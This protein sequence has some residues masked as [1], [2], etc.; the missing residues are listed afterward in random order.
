MIADVNKYDL[1]QW[2]GNKVCAAGTKATSFLVEQ[3]A[4]NST[5]AWNTGALLLVG[6]VAVITVLWISR[7]RQE[8]RDGYYWR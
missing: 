4:C 7:R 1:V 8:R 2:L 6:I 5:E 3:P